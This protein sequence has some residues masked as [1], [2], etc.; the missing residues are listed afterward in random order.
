MTEEVIGNMESEKTELLDFL[1]HDPEIVKVQQK[2]YEGGEAVVYGLYEGQR[3]LI[4]A[5]LTKQRTD[6]NLLVLCDT[7]KR[8]KEL[9]ED[10]VNLL[11]DYEALYFPA[12]EMIPYEV[13][14]QSGELEQKRLE[15]LS[16]LVLERDKKFAVVTTI[17]G[18]SK[19]LLP[20]GDFRQGILPL[21]VG[22]QIAQNQLRAHLAAFGYEFEIGRAHV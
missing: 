9:W 3:T 21:E 8:A 5:A 16:R 10:L 19:R 11:P 17:E 13:I 4:T 15:V 20:A 12:L 2:L 18:L 6:G 1:Q 14:A 7:E 22:Q